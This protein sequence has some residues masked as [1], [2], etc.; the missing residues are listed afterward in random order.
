MTC[1]RAKL[2]WKPFARVGFLGDQRR[3]NVA[4][5]RAKSSLWALGHE[6][7]L[8]NDKTWCELCDDARTRSVT[9]DVPGNEYFEDRNLLHKMR[10]AGMKVRMN[11]WPRQTNGSSAG[12]LL[13]DRLRRT[14]LAQRVF[15]FRTGSKKK[16]NLKEIFCFALLYYF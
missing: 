12:E 15:Q 7:T 3:M 14:S 1:V 13:A 10:A 6:D 8:R 16:L 9:V 4:L 11:Q 2:Y 5:T